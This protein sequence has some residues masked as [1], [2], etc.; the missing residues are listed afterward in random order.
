M[1]GLKIDFNMVGMVLY[2]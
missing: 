1:N 2:W